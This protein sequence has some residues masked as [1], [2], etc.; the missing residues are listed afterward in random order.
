MGKTGMN[1][2]RSDQ[3]EMRI[4]PCNY[5]VFNLQHKISYSRH[6]ESHY[7]SRSGTTPL[8]ITLVTMAGF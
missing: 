2:L 7:D 8:S 3:V 6:R 1:V 5:G 4:Y